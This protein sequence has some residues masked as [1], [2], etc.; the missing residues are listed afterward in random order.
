MGLKRLQS[1]VILYVAHASARKIKY[2]K[3]ISDLQT[4]CPV[5]LRLM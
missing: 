3:I 5:D 4:K 2:D 1:L